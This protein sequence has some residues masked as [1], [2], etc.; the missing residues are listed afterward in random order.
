MIKKRVFFGSI[1]VVLIYLLYLLYIFVISPKTNL[2]PIYLIPKDAVF[3]IE[4]ETPVESWKAVSE[5]EAWSHLTGNDYFSELTENIQKVDTIFNQRKRLF[6]FF[7]DRSLYISIHMISPKDYGIF[8]VLDLKRI[9]KLK[10][11][12]TYL[13]TL[14]NENYSLSKRQ[15]HGHEILEIFDRKEKETFHL[16]FVKNQLVASYTHTLVEASI[17]QYQE[18]ALGRN[19]NFIEVNKK[20]G[21]EDLFR[22]Y[23]QYDYLDDYI[24]QYSNQTSPWVKRASETFLFSGFHLDLDEKGNLSADGF[25]NIDLKN[26]TY[27]QALQKSGKSNRT[28][29][30][31][32][33]KNTALYLSYGFDDFSE[34]YKNFELLL[35]ENPERFKSYQEGISTIEKFLK[36]DVEEHFVSWIGSEMGILQLKS[37]NQNVKND[38]ALILKTKD[39]EV[40]NKNLDFVLKQI[41]KRTPVKF[42]AVQYKGHEINFLSIKGFFKA[43]LG[44]RF[45]EFDKP[46]FTQID[47]FVIF[48]NNP[49]TLKSIIDGVK[50]GQTLN[51]SEEFTEFDRKFEDESSL[52]VFANVPLLYDT[53]LSS[54]DAQTKILLRKNKDFLICFPNAG[55]QLTPAEDLFETR[56]V[57]DYLDVEDVREND[58]YVK[59]VS[60]KSHQPVSRLPKEITTAVFNLPPINPVDLSAN[61]FIKKY[62]SGSVKYEVHLKDGK[63][64]GRYQEFY[65]NGAKKM[66][67]RFK[68]DEQIGTWRYYNKEGE[69]LIKKQL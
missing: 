13:N 10:L 12:K 9:A 34:F 63:K 15:Y 53:F 64:H 47:D 56:L 44:G 54:A 62:N 38:L 7:D 49:N 18:P 35:N 40:A 5:S 36:I 67:G 28:I 60:R 31:I 61:F 3:V 41:K 17:D 20:V 58:F 39:K 32:A 8:Y 16:A 14:L 6:E 23:L 59:K 22:L 68:N 43:I 30:R 26:E 33:P 25:T 11:L 57:L 2:Q 19:L 50:L 21:Y 24:R 45:D 46:Y 4:S 65:P 37:E 48:S 52:Y 27:L 69:L 42:K 66:T 29:P 55:F 1:G 51:Y